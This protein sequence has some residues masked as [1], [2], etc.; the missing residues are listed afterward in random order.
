MSDPT[1]PDPRIDTLAAEVDRLRK[2]RHSADNQLQQMLLKIT[3]IQLNLATQD[4]MLA[5]LDIAVRGNG[6][7]G[8]STRVDRIERTTINLLKFAWIIIAALATTAAE[9]AARLYHR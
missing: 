3:E 9:V 5:K 2:S 6:K 8:L 4:A 7:P 1:P